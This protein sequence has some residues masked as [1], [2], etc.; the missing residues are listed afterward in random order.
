MRAELSALPTGVHLAHRCRVR[1]CDT[2]SRPA[3]AMQAQSPCG[4]A[5]AIS[6][7]W[8]PLCLYYRKGRGSRRP[9]RQL[10]RSLRRRHRWRGTGSTG[11]PCR[12]ARPHK[13]FESAKS[14]AQGAGLLIRLDARNCVTRSF[15]SASGF[16]P[17]GVPYRP[18][19]AR[20]GRSCAN[21]VFEIVFDKE[22]VEMESEKVH[23]RTGLVKH[24][25]EWCRIC[26]RRDHCTRQCSSICG[27]ERAANRAPGDSE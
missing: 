17:N 5:Q 23:L 8:P 11:R 1:A 25:Q 7:P 22:W 21:R 18:L 6:P 10:A 13:C 14:F 4:G 16:H 27:L 19:L 26:G 3:A 20:S 9:R 15:A 2:A 24:C 12:V